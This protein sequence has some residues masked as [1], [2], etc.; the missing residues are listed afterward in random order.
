MQILS[1]TLPLDLMIELSGRR[2]KLPPDLINSKYLPEIGNVFVPKKISCCPKNPGY[3]RG[4][5]NSHAGYKE[6]ARSIDAEDL[7]SYV[8][9][10]YNKSW[11]ILET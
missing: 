2:L 6:S 7:R 8:L 10:I 4:R 11:S 1:K 9:H 3:E 5:K